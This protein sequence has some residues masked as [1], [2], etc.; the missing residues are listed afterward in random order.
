MFATS[1]PSPHKN[2]HPV[3]TRLHASTSFPPAAP[4]HTIV[5]AS[6][7]SASETV[8]G[9]E[10]H[11][12]AVAPYPYDV[13][14]AQDATAEPVAEADAADEGGWDSRAVFMPVSDVVPSAALRKWFP[15]CTGISV[16]EGGGI[17]SIPMPA[18]NQPGSSAAL[19]AALMLYCSFTATPC[20][21]ALGRVV[22]YL[23]Q[24]LVRR[25]AR[26]ASER[27][28]AHV[29]GLGGVP[30]G[31]AGSEASH[32][33]DSERSDGGT[34]ARASQQVSRFQVGTLISSIAAGTANT[35]PHLFK[36]APAGAAASIPRRERG[37][38]RTTLDGEGSCMCGGALPRTRA[39]HPSGGIYSIARRS[40]LFGSVKNSLERYSRARLG[41][42]MSSSNTGVRVQQTA[43]IPRSISIEVRLNQLPQNFNVGIY[44]AALASNTCSSRLRLCAIFTAPRNCL[45]KPENA[46]ATFTLQPLPFSQ[47]TSVAH[48]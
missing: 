3:S 44:P 32:G 47:S 18:R 17:S 41:V 46:A 2:P 5:E 33:R 25:V 23:H 43:K 9:A 12:A 40:R 20:L 6:P 48:F 28:E 22:P 34:R 39:V 8:V 24:G 4:M 15:L 30:I 45:F 13:Q 38:T 7:G 1:S 21:F 29:R 11:A 26:R 19:R 10:E 42:Q 27:T 36:R 31:S 16:D 37:R 14:P 35:P